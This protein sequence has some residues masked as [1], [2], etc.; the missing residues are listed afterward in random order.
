MKARISKNKIEIMIAPNLVLKLQKNSPYIAK[1]TSTTLYFYSP[2]MPTTLPIPV[3][4][5]K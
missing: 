3:P 2:F 1:M 5:V 4:I